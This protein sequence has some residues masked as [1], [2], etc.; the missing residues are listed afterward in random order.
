MKNAN[1]NHTITLYKERLFILVSDWPA[2]ASEASSSGSGSSSGGGTRR[3]TRELALH[4]VINRVASAMEN[5]LGKAPTFFEEFNGVGGE[6]GSRLPLT[7]DGLR[8]WLSLVSGD[9]HIM[10][11]RLLCIGDEKKKRASMFSAQLHIEWTARKHWRMVP[12]VSLLERTRWSVARKERMLTYTHLDPAIIK[13]RKDDEAGEDQGGEGEDE[14]N[15]TIHLYLS[16]CIRAR[17]LTPDEASAVLS[18]AMHRDFHP[19]L[20]VD[21]SAGDANGGKDGLNPRDSFLA[22]LGGGPFRFASY[23]S[24]RIPKAVEDISKALE[25]E[26]ADTKAPPPR[27]GASLLEPHPYY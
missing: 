14:D 9:G 25:D 3:R 23:L 13:E 11:P 5:A 2:A 10:L 20:H 19:W 8:L 4:Q 6:G 18:Q 17:P 1:E 16:N 15:P 24:W 22:A 26:D 12:T 7:P 21:S 27:I